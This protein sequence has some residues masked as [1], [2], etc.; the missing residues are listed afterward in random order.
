[1]HYILP[2]YIFILPQ[3]PGNFTSTC[4]IISN[5]RLTTAQMYLNS[6]EYD[7]AIS[8]RTRRQT[9]LVPA[10]ITS[11]ILNC[12]NLGYYSYDVWR[13]IRGV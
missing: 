5:A 6:S 3:R 4:G 10:E 2:V 12:S 8:R 13:L 9:V 11:G 7:T 1:M